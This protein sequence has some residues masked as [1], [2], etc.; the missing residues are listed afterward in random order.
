[1][2]HFLVESFSGIPWL[3]PAQPKFLVGV[4]GIIRNIGKIDRRR[5]HNFLEIA[6][7]YEL[8]YQDV[9]EIYH[10]V[11]T[12]NAE[13]KKNIEGSPVN[14]PISLQELVWKSRLSWNIADRSPD[15]QRVWT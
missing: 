13:E 4:G 15:Y 1:M 8:S 10:Q 12:K 14:D 11:K 2:H 7:N 6:H 3:K 9:N 5:K